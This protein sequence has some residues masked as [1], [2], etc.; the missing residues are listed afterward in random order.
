MIVALLILFL[1]M[2]ESDLILIKLER[3]NLIV[4]LVPTT[5]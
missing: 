2:L 5:L 4:V 1:I 3:L